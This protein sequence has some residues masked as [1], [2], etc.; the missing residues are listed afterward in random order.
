MLP[1]ILESH[2]PAAQGNIISKPDWQTRSGSPDAYFFM[3]NKYVKQ[4]SHI[5]L[6]P[7]ICI[8]VTLNII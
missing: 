5:F 7:Y 2:K 4:R 8:F 1:E 6:L 3:L